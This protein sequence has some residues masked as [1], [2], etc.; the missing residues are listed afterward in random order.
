MFEANVHRWARSLQPTIRSRF[1]EGPADQRAGTV[2]NQY[3]WGKRIFGIELTRSKAVLFVAFARQTMPGLKNV[4]F[5][6]ALAG[7]SEGNV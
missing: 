7:Q 4:N 5:E 6:T 3:V 2:E 1:R